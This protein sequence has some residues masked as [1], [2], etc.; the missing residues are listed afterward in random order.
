MPKHKHKRAKGFHT[1]IC[2]IC[3]FDS[4][5]GDGIDFGMLNFERHKWGGVRHDQLVYMAYDLELFQTLS[6][7]PAPV[8]EGKQI[9]RRILDACKSSKNF[10]LLKSSLAKIVKSNDSERSQLCQILAYAGII[11]PSDCPSFTGS[12][13]RWDK[14]GD[15]RPRSDMNY[16]L[17]WR[18]G[19]GYREPGVEHWFPG[20]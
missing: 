10:S 14:R 2:A 13:I 4:A 5:H 9:L 19:S 11:Q 15:G 7:P 8:E 3:G 12:Y 1:D 18:R 16:P 20:L 17:G 6:I